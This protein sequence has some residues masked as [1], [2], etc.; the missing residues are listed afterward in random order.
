MAERNLLTLYSELLNTLVK[1]V[2]SLYQAKTKADTAD[3]SNVTTHGILESLG[4]IEQIGPGLEVG[5]KYTT[6]EDTR[7]PSISTNSSSS[8]IFTSLEGPPSSDNMS[9]ISDQAMTGIGNLSSPKTTGYMADLQTASTEVPLLTPPPWQSLPTLPSA[10]DFHSFDPHNSMLFL[11]GTELLEEITLPSSTWTMDTA[12][13]MPHFN[14][15][16]SAMF[17]VLPL[18]HAHFAEIESP[19]RS[20]L[21]AAREAFGFDPTPPSPKH[22]LVETGE[23]EMSNSWP[24]FAKH[25]R[26]ESCGSFS[27]GMESC[28]CAS[29]LPVTHPWM[30]GDL[31]VMTTDLLLHSQTG[32]PK[33]V[34]SSPRSEYSPSSS[35]PKR[36][37]GRPRLEESDELS[38]FGSV[39]TRRARKQGHKRNNYTTPAGSHIP[40]DEKR[41]MSLEQ[42]RCAASKCREKKRREI[43]QLKETSH[44]TAAENRFLKQ[45]T[46]RLRE[47]TESLR[48]ELLVHM[49]NHEC[50]RPDEVR[51]F[52]DD[53]KVQKVS[54]VSQK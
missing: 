8:Q 3:I 35:P 39:S 36:R 12:S 18:S 25:A 6:Q 21:E 27:S 52:L 9:S 47:E 4:L 37:K 26:H 32:S 34:D 2:H 11:F 31:S 13:T 40:E 28:V 17:S 45:Q 44:D 16:I 42:N 29:A 48:L 1:A 51:S 41:R 50:Q 24:S 22:N 33:V 19:E 49:S 30:Q 54:Q 46:T 15:N 14:D 23:V 10:N 5:F 20:Q 53:N 7:S 38:D 43:E